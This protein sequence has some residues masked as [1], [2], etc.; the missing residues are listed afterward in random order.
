MANKCMELINENFGFSS[1]LRSIGLRAIN[2]KDTFESYQTE[3]F[4][5]FKAAEE[6]QAVEDK[7]FLIKQKYCKDSIVRGATVNINIRDRDE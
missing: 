1:P 5:D 3:M 6:R 7:V 2:L 4:T